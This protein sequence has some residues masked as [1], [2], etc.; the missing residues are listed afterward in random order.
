MNIDCGNVP[1]LVLLFVQEHKLY[2][3]AIYNVILSDVTAPPRDIL[4]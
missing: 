3:Y 1:S 4:P 2:I